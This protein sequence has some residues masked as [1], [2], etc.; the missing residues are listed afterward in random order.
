MK[1]VGAPPG[2]GRAGFWRRRGPGFVRPLPGWP[3]Q[4]GW[5]RRCHG[6]VVLTRSSGAAVKQR[7][8]CRAV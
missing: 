1:A 8:V 3:G 6:I 7:L 4:H 2:C 5:W